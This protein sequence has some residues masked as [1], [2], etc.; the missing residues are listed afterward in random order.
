MN[1]KRH[2]PVI[3][4]PLTICTMPDLIRLDSWERLLE[5]WIG[6]DPTRGAYQTSKRGRLV[7]IRTT[8]NR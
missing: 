4:S 1:K 6:L 3:G 8:G 7:G 2:I 5:P